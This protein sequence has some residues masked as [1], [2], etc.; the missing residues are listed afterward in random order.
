MSL[1][2]YHTNSDRLIFIVLYAFFEATMLFNHSIIYYFT[3]VLLFFLSVA[4]F[5]SK[6]TKVVFPFFFVYYAMFVAYAYIQ[7]NYIGVYNLKESTFMFGVVTQNLFAYLCLFFVIYNYRSVDSALRAYI[8]ASVIQVIVMFALSQMIG[9]VGRFGTDVDI[10]LWGMTFNYN[11]NSIAM[12]ACVSLS[13]LILDR[14]LYS[15]LSSLIIGGLLFIALLLSGSKKTLFIIVCAF[16]WY[17]FMGEK[18][19]KMR[20]S[21]FV[22][23]VLLSAI[24]IVTI[25]EIVMNVPVFYEVIG[26]R[27]EDM[28]DYYN[29][30]IGDS[31][32]QT[33]DHLIEMGMDNFYKHPYWGIGLNNFKSF[34][35]SIYYSHNDYV[36]LLSSVGIIG[37]IIAYLPKL[38]ILLRTLVS[39]PREYRHY[40]FIVLEYFIVAFGTVSYYKRED[41]VVLI[42]IL[43]LLEINKKTKRLREIRK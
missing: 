38:N 21:T 42:V 22:K 1:V 2:K 30:G 26:V 5:S 39:L 7:I 14:S 15:S 11:A 10:N 19:N 24:I 43:G 33:R 18:H 27:I 29:G 28:F 13:L 36:E 20:S 12:T 40:I 35:D 4:S 41:W 6:S 25:Y 3:F 37:T 17:G 34:N 23:R 8:L 31:S 32:T 9:A 16:I